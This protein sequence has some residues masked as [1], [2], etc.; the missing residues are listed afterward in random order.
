MELAARVDLGVSDPLPFN[1]LEIEQTR[2]I[3]ESMKS[4]HGH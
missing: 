3:G 1:V 4:H 2:A